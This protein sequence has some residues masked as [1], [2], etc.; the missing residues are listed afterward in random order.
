[1][2]ETSQNRPCG[3]RK[4][5]GQM[6]EKLE[7]EGHTLEYESL[8]G[9]DLLRV[10]AHFLDDWKADLGGESSEGT[11]TPDGLIED[12]RALAETAEGS[13]AKRLNDDRDLDDLAGLLM[14]SE[15]LVGAA[16][17]GLRASLDALIGGYLRYEGRHWVQWGRIEAFTHFAWVEE[18]RTPLLFRLITIAGQKCGIERENHG[19]WG[20]HYHYLDHKGR[21][22]DVIFSFSPSDTSKPPQLWWERHG[23][24]KAAFSPDVPAWGTPKRTSIHKACDLDLAKRKL[25]DYKR[26]SREA[27]VLWPHR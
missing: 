11:H 25:A 18:E 26:P 23:E 22:S 15:M 20:Y 6:D 12:A 9:L 24:G 27:C 13:I 1:M 16:D 14:V 10:I 3:N 19:S 5:G 4:A 7:N 21:R 8:A 17:A 2:W